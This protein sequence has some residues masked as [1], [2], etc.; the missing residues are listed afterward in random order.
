MTHL[1][2]QLAVEWSVLTRNVC[3]FVVMMQPF[4]FDPYEKTKH[5]FMIQSLVVGADIG[6]RD[7]VCIESCP[8][9]KLYIYMWG[10]SLVMLITLVFANYVV[11][12]PTTVVSSHVISNV[13]AVV[14]ARCR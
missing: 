9:L 10:V 1:L 3:F 5:K 11:S 13:L 12:C 2:T 7:V 8:S 14:V 6:D 4:E